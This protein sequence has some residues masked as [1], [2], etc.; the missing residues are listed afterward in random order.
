MIFIRAL[1]LSA[2]SL[3]ALSG[4]DEAYQGRQMKQR[5][6]IPGL[7]F[8]AGIAFGVGITILVSASWSQNRDQYDHRTISQ[9]WPPTTVRSM[10]T[11]APSTASSA[12]ADPESGLMYFPVIE[13]PNASQAPNGKASPFGW[14]VYSKYGPYILGSGS[15]SQPSAVLKP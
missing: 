12:S 5:W 14:R 10:T 1:L 13:P 4:L 3:I 6:L 8:A 9:I 7:T 11:A 15:T 2:T